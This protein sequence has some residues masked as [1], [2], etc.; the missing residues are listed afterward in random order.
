MQRSRGAAAARLDF[1]AAPILRNADVKIEGAHH[2]HGQRDVRAFVEL[3]FDFDGRRLRCEGSEQQQSGY[4]LRERA[5]N[6]D[7]PAPRPARR[8][9]DRRT[10]AGGLKADAQVRERIEQRPDR[11]AAKVLLRR[12][13][14]RR[15]GER[16]QADHEVERRAG[17]A[18]RNDPPFHVIGAAGDEQR[19]ALDFDLRPQRPQH[20]HRELHVASIGKAE[21]PA[22]PGRERCENERS[23]RVIFRVRYL[24]L[25]GQRPAR[26]FDEKIHRRPTSRQSAYNLPSVKERTLPQRETTSDA[27]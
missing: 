17:T 8:D 10:A 2:L 12:Q 26:S 18:D 19:L 21:D 3:A 1:E 23:V 6:D 24:D 5:G 16:C 27:F 7:R 11:T 25:T 9:R 13:R 22:R 20:V 14:Y 15:V 4:P